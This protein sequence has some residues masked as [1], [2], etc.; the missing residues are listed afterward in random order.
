MIKAISDI[1]SWEF[2]FTDET[3]TMDYLLSEMINIH[4][5]RNI[6]IILKASVYDSKLIEKLQ[7]NEIVDIIRKVPVRTQHDDYSITDEILEFT[8]SNFQLKNVIV[9]NNIDSFGTIIIKLLNY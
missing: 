9:Q 3:I 5:N 2:I 4:S 7:A 6:A 1:S 8:Y